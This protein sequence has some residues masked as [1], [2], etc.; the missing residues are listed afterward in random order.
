MFSSL[1]QEAGGGSSRS[2]RSGGS[3]R[4]A[5]RAPGTKSPGAAVAGGSSPQQG[6]TSSRSSLGSPDAQNAP[7]EAA[8][9][10]IP[11]FF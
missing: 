7:L 3:P 4:G 2:L 10:A 8:G 6:G 11:G 9:V 5:L 1:L